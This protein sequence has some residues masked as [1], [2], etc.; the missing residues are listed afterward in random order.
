MITVVSISLA[1]LVIVAGLLLLAKTKKDELGGLFTFSSYAVITCGI[2]LAAHA[3]VGCMV[4]CHSNSGKGGCGKSSYSHCSKSGGGHG[5]CASYGKSC[6]KSG[7]AGYKHGKDEGC[8]KSSSCSKGSKSCSSKG[9]HGCKS[10]GKK[11]E[12]R[13]IIKKSGDGEKDIDVTIEVIE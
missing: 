5:S 1:L 4:N 2:L 9:K 6:S 3:F 10:S 8:S 11:K 7:D 13:K 12:I